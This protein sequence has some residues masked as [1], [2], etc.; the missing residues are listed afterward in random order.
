MLIVEPF[1]INVFGIVASNSRNAQVN[2]DESDAQWRIYGPRQFSVA[3]VTSFDRLKRSLVD[4]RLVSGGCI[5]YVDNIA[6]VNADDK[7]HERILRK[8]KAFIHEKEFRIFFED[9]QRRGVNSTPEGIYVEVDCKVMIQKVV[10][11]PLSPNWFVQNVSRFLKLLK[12]E[13]EVVK[14]DLYERGLV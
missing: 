4:G 6:F 10:I 14:S 5:D 7:K 2:E 3:I 9:I 8:R 12:L 13:L 1:T 11:S